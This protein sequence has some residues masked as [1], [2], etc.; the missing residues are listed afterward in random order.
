MKIPLSIIIP[1]YNEEERIEKT[2]EKIFNYKNA[3]IP[4]IIIVDDGSKDKTYQILL[5][6]KERYKNLKILQ[7]EKNE[8]KGS[9]LKKG[10]LASDDKIPYILISDSDLSS[11]IEEVERFF[12]YLKDYAILIGSRGLDRSYIK[13]HQPFLREFMG[14]VF[15]RIVQ[16]LFFPKIYDTQCGFKLFKTRVAKEIFNEIK[17]KGFSYDVEVLILAKL[18]GY[19]F[20]EVPVF[21]YHE[22]KSKVKLTKAPFMMFFELINLYLSYRNLLKAS[23]PF[24]CGGKPL[25][26]KA[27]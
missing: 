10:I 8:G 1:A 2:I 26:K 23:K 24:F 14:I 15:N 17:I 27:Y 12:P 9:A 19:R 13:K 16:I 25:R 7:N 5:N 20:K 21:W 11:P 3:D 18:K 6:L 22:G 4:E